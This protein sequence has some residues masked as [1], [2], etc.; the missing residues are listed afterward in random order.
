VIGKAIKSLLASAG[1]IYPHR[2]TQGASLPYVT[3][4]VISNGPTD[5][6]EGVSE[7]DVVRVQVDSFATTYSACATLSDTVRSTLDRYRGTVQT[8]VIDKIVFEGEADMYDEDAEVY[9][10]SQD[11]FVR[12]KL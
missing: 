11:F 10:R 1:D 2:A 6:K 5:T 12:I 8:I 9:Q 7:L 4:R 3:Y